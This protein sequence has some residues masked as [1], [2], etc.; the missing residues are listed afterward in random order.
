MPCS[1][2]CDYLQKFDVCPTRAASHRTVSMKTAT[3]YKNLF[4]PHLI[5]QADSTI[6]V[7]HTHLNITM[8]RPTRAIPLPEGT[9]TLHFQQEPKKLGLPSLSAIE[10]PD[11]ISYKITIHLA[12]EAIGH[13]VAHVVNKAR[14]EAISAARMW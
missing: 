14:M 8:N 1:L 3:S 2:L 6:L 10:H 5:E 11:I 12:N 7:D 13:I 9:I 4:I